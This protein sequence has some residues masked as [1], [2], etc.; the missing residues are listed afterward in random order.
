MLATSG[1]ND[2]ENFIGLKGGRSCQS[3]RIDG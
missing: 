1:A 2:A 3:E